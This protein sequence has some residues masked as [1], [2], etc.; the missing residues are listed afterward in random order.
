MR[1]V[2]ACVVAAALLASCSGD[3]DGGDDAADEA[4]FCRLADENAPVSEAGAGV[5]RRMEEL[6]PARL[7]DDVAVLRDL[8]ERLEDHDADDPDALALEFEVRFSDEHVAARAAVDAFVKQEC[9][10][11]SVTSTSTSTSTTAPNGTG[12]GDGAT[13]DGSMGQDGADADER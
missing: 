9:A 11:P 12:G 7:E 13:S 1:R 3:D 4:S 10:R 6:A 5:L 8:A 2:G